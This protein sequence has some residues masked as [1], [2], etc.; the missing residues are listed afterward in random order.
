MQHQRTQDS[1]PTSDARQDRGKLGIEVAE[2]LIRLP[3]RSNLGG[4]Y[5]GH[6]TDS[7]QT[8]C[9]MCP[10]VTIHAVDCVDIVTIEVP[11]TGTG[12]FS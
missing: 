10:N 6:V 4:L 3:T 5:G 12:S 7:I 8:C 9:P 11:T 2:A 1:A